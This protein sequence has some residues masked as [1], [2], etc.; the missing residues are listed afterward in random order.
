VRRRLCRQ[1]V[2]ASLAAVIAVV[3]AA[4]GS[5]GSTALILATHGPWCPLLEVH[6]GDHLDNDLRQKLDGDDPPSC[7]AEVLGTHPDRIKQELADHIFD[8][9]QNGACSQDKKPGPLS[10]EPGFLVIT[11]LLFA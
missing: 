4:L 11:R 5:A 7:V 3:A 10:N 1:G 6:A 8:R 2:L 9:P